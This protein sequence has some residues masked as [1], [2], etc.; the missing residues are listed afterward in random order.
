M[1]FLISQNLICSFLQTFI[2]YLSIFNTYVISNI[3]L[4]IILA[5]V[6]CRRLYVVML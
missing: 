4:K 3:Y 5:F 6:F 2:M 1:I